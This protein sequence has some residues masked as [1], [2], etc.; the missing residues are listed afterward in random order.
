ML[1]NCLPRQADGEA[2]CWTYSQAYADAD[3]LETVAYTT[4]NDCRDLCFANEECVGVHV[5]SYW[6]IADAKKCVLGKSGDLVYQVGK[7]SAKNM[8]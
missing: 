4:F 3:V 1:I 2:T 6:E 8:I 7:I 5:T